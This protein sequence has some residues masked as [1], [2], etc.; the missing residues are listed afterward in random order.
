MSRKSCSR[1]CQWFP[2]PAGDLGKQGKGQG[3][4]ARDL[5]QPL[6]TWS[7]RACRKGVLV[8]TPGEAPLP[9]RSRA[10]SGIPGSTGDVMALVAFLHDL[11]A[12]I[13]GS[14]SSREAMSGFFR[15]KPSM[16]SGSCL[17][18]THAETSPLAY[19][20]ECQVGDHPVDVGGNVPQ[21][22][23]YLSPPSF[24]MSCSFSLI[25]CTFSVW[26]H[27]CNTHT[28]SWV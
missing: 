5:F 8:S 24:V 13:T 15:A 18:G 9:S 19:G 16:T 20:R 22:V 4:P 12:Q 28:L 25:P 26:M 10:A 14:S 23:R 27:Y 6:S 1:H 11:G 2:F 7:A 3:D 17:P 21:R